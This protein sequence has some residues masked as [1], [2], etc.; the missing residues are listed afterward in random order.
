MMNVP[1]L[2]KKLSSICLLSL[3]WKCKYSCIF[4]IMFCE[5]F[6]KAHAKISTYDI[7]DIQVSVDVLLYSFRL[8]REVVKWII[9]QTHALPLC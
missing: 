6:Q 3:V 1:Q 7:K 8:K 2:R 9:K 4:Q 5:T